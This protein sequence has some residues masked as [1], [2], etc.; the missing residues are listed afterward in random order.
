MVDQAASWPLKDNPADT[1]LG[2][3]A[4]A[5]FGGLRLFW[6]RGSDP[7]ILSTIAR[8]R[9]LAQES[10][11]SVVVEHCPLSVKQQIDVW[12]DSFQGMEIMRRIKQKFDPLGILNPG[13]FAGRL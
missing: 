8:L 1:T 6:W 12:G 2:R 5:G 3:V 11:S 13:R 10:N 9:K 4:D 7:A